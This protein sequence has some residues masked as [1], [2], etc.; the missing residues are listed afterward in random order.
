MCEQTYPIK[1]YSHARLKEYQY[2]RT[3]RK[4][5][6]SLNRNVGN[7]RAID[8]FCDCGCNGRLLTWPERSISKWDYTPG[9]CPFQ[10][11]IQLR[12]IAFHRNEDIDIHIM[13]KLLKVSRQL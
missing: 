2:Q 12:R 6:W 11:G 1:Y 8:L 3:L 10:V 7:I 13:E 4:I 5:D 9:S